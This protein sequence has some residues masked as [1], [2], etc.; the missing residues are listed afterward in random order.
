MRNGSDGT[1][2]LMNLRAR[3]WRRSRAFG[4]AGPS[5]VTARRTGLLMLAT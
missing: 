2:D 3:T 5:V 4:G 1:N